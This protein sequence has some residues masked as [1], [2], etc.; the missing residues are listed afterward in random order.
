MEDKIFLREAKGGLFSVKF[1]YQFLSEIE[2][3]PFPSKIVW[4]SL[5]PCNVGFFVWEASW[6]RILTLDQIKR[7]GRALANRCFL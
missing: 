1:V 4:N 5:V 2:V 3:H 6:G 7:R